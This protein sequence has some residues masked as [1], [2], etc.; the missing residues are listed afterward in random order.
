MY[1]HTLFWRP[2]RQWIG[3]IWQH[4]NMREVH[5]Q[6]VKDSL[7]NTQVLRETFGEAA[8]ICTRHSVKVA[9]F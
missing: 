6:G 4:G 3:G 2:C 5:F 9:P 1:L 7:E 8:K